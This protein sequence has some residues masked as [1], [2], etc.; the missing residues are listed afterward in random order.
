[1]IFLQCGCADAFHQR[2]CHPVSQHFIQTSSFMISK[3]E[4][5][6]RWL[7]W[8]NFSRTTTILSL[9][10]RHSTLSLFSFLPLWFPPSSLSSCVARAELPPLAMGQSRYS[11]KTILLLSYK[12][13]D[14]WDSMCKLTYLCSWRK[15]FVWIFWESSTVVLRLPYIGEG[16]LQNRQTK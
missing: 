14:K 8:P 16:N 11:G 15:G 13:G 3:K 5:C 1:M 9:S 4:Q 2:N 12:Q 6:S 10:F 7:I